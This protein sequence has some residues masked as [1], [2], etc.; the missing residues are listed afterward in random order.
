MLY[1]SHKHSNGESGS[2]RKGG[3]NSGTAKRDGSKSDRQTEAIGACEVPLRP[4]ASSVLQPRKDKRRKASKKV[5][6]RRN[7]DNEWH[8]DKKVP[9]SIIGAILLQT[10]AV[11]WWVSSLSQKVLSLEQSFTEIKVE[12][13][14]QRGKIDRLGELDVEIRNLARTIAR[15]E[16]TL[17]RLLSPQTEARRS[18]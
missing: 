7:P 17:D 12:S 10:F 9:I 5:M 4:A 2:T 1:A 6:A 16:S 15:I 8:L 3:R 11:G 18:K 14:E 13:K